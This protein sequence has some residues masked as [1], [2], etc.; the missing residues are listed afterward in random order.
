VGTLSVVAPSIQLPV[1]DGSTAI[2]VSMAQPI[3]EN[4]IVIQWTLETVPPGNALELICG[5]AV[6]PAAGFP[7]AVVLDSIGSAPTGAEIH[8]SGIWCIKS[9]Q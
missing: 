5:D 6:F 7:A 9:Y 2:Y 8:A 3:H 1:G 4:A